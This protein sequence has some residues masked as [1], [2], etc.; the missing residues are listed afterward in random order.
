[1]AATILIIF[2]LKGQ[3]YQLGYPQNSITMIPSILISI[4]IQVYNFA[5]SKI[6]GILVDF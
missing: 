6:I 3:L 5:Y 4:S 1:M 2:T